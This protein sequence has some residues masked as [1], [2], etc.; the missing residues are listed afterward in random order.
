VKLTGKTVLI[1][2][3]SSGLGRALA[4]ALAAR[5]NTIV[6]TARRADRLAA[7]REEIT[8]AG[9]R[10]VDLPGDAADPADVTR[11]LDEARRAVGP[12]DVAVLNAGGGRPLRMVEASA[13]DVLAVMR[14]NYDTFANYLLPLLQE[15]RGRGGVIAYTGSPAGYFGLPLS[16]PYSAAKAAGRTLLDACRLELVGSPLKLVAMYPG[17]TRTEGLDPDAVPVPALLIE[18]DRAVREMIGAMESERAHAMFPKRIWALMT[19]ARAL[20][21]PVR[22]RVLARF[23]V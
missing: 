19:L 1:T 18:C 11:V 21:E 16:G 2:G 5:G 3:A 17:F 15:M 23:A 4:V 12:I 8:R 10:C 9:G 6:A 14:M 20:P 13:A 7:L 22:R